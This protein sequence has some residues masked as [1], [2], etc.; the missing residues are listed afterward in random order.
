MS[1]KFTNKLSNVRQGF[2]KPRY[3]LFNQ[4]LFIIIYLLR[5]IDTKKGMARHEHNCDTS[6]YIGRIYSIPLIS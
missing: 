2:F 4:I 6:H 1:N 5:I 3:H